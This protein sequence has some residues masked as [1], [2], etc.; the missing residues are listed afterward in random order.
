MPAWTSTVLPS[1]SQGPVFNRDADLKKWL[2]YVADSLDE[3]AG[4]RLT[5]AD[6]TTLDLKPE[7]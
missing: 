1:P 6:G 5:W 2:A 4:L 3:V 7:R